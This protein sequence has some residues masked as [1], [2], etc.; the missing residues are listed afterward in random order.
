MQEEVSCQKNFFGKVTAYQ[1]HPFCMAFVFLIVVF[2][3]DHYCAG[4][5]LISIAYSF[6]P[7]SKKAENHHPTVLIKKATLTLLRTLSVSAGIHSEVSQ[8]EA[9]GTLCGLMRNI[10]DCGCNYGLSMYT[11]KLCIISVRTW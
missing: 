3:I 7:D 9:V 8:R 5:Y 2:F 10:V 4:G 6:F 1:T 11:F